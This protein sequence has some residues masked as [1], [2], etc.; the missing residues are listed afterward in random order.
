MGPEKRGPCTSSLGSVWTGVQQRTMKLGKTPTRFVRFKRRDRCLV[1]QVEPQKVGKPQAKWPW[2]VSRTA[3]CGEQQYEFQELRMAWQK[4]RDPPSPR[5][6]SP[7]QWWMSQKM[8]SVNRRCKGSD[9]LPLPPPHAPDSS[10]WFYRCLC[11]LGKIQV[12]IWADLTV[13]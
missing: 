5:M 8:L 6:E 9:K 11:N 3:H 2:R 1:S 13:D 7:V 10:T 4:I 12:K